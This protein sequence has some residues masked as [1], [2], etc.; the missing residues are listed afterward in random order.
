MALTLTPPA[1]LGPER[2]LLFGK[3]GTG[4]T[5]A[6]LSIARRIPDA[7]FYVIDTDYSASYS[8]MMAT[9]FTDVLE[10]GNVEQYIVGPD[11]WTKLMDAAREVGRKIRQGD[12]LIVDSMSPTWDAVQGFFTEQVHG[13]DIESY[14]LDKRREIADAKKE[15]KDAGKTPKRGKAAATTLEAFEGWMD[16]S[17]INPMYSRLY[18]LITQQPGHLLITAEGTPLGNEEQKTVKDI[19]GPFSLKPRGQKKLGFLTH[20]VLLTSKDRAGEWYLDT[21]KDRGR[22]EMV[23]LEMTDFAKQYLQGVAGWKPKKA[24]I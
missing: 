13:H 22:E 9:E 3:E 23:E 5:N 14:L 2:I 4:K 20:T 15:A 21:V 6:V 11:D 7:T 24:D 10:Q 12:W 19:Y 1:G 17:V 16:W 8:R 18:K